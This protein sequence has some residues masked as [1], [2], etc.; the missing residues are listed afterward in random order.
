MSRQVGVSAVVVIIALM[1]GG[2]LMGIVGAIL[3]VPSAAIL[4]VFFQEIAPD[5][6]GE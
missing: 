4:H 6:V 2:A 1:L 3:A 5:A